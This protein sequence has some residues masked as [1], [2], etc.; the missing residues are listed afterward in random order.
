MRE[1]GRC[2]MKV[3][4]VCASEQATPCR[5]GQSHIVNST[6]HT[7]T[8]MHD[9][10]EGGFT[11]VGDWAFFLS[12]FF[13]LSLLS[14]ARCKGGSCAEP[15][16]R[17]RD[18]QRETSSECR[19]TTYRGI[20]E[21]KTP[22]TCPSSLRNIGLAREAVTQYTGNEETDATIWTN[23]RRK[24]IRPK[25]RQFIYKT[26]HDVFKVGNYW[27]RIQ[28]VAEC[29]LCT[30]CGEAESMNHILIQCQNSPPRTVWRLAK[31]TW[32]HDNIPWS[33]IDLGTVL[34]RTI[35]RLVSLTLY[36]PFIHNA[37]ASIQNEGE[38]THAYDTK[39]I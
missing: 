28:V 36:P 35:I 19:L 30:A 32:P 24:A 26:M 37:A 1:A 12:L 17:P 2:E 21:R 9:R 34:R 31:E 16:I 29:R 10:C 5:N 33:E 6:V 14:R 38:N 27:A 15:G 20:L 3:V 22:P 18:P 23:I 13:E 7:R 25:I 11:P 39:T 8:G 4:E